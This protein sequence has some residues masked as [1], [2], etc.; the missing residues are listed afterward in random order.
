MNLVI[1]I[2]FRDECSNRSCIQTL[3]IN[4]LLGGEKERIGQGLDPE[5]ILIK[6]FLVDFLKFWSKMTKILTKIA[7]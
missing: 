5:K 4:V 6:S 1:S 7:I 2:I 3:I